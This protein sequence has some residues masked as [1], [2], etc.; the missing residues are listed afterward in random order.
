MT[1]ANSTPSSNL[2]P[3]RGSILVVDDQRNMRIT[4]AL[5]L[6]AEG[7]SVSDAATG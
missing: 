7:Y 1:D 6:R 5:I 4:T 2:P 3:H